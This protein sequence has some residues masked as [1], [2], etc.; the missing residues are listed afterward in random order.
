MRIVEIGAL[1]VRRSIEIEAPPERVWREFES[2]ER[3]RLWYSTEGGAVMPCYALTYEPR[4]GGEF[5]TQVRHG[6]SD[7][8]FT[9]TVVAYD[10]PRELTVEM[11]PIPAAG[12][13]SEVTLISFLLHPLD[14]GR[15][16]MEIVHHGFEA[17]GDEA[18][19][20]YQMFE[21]GW[22]MAVPTA[23]KNLVETGSATGK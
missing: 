17:F 1:A 18:E 10:P 22:D 5:S 4:V 13:R 11:G 2:E 14:R 6:A 8:K 9:G 23:L 7:I 19:R 20:V 21:G 12:G 16:K 3:L 15:T